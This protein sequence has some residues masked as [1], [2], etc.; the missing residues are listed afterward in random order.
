MKLTSPN[1]PEQYDKFEYCT[2]KI[3]APLGH[4]VILDFERIE[5]S[6]IQLRDK[7]PFQ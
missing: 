6:Y 7:T 1:Y 3:F 2:W 4:L 5:V